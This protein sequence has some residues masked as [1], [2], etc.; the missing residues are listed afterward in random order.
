MPE[1]TIHSEGIDITSEDFNHVSTL[2][3]KTFDSGVVNLSESISTEWSPKSDFFS[4]SLAGKHVWL[5]AKSQADLRDKLLYFQ[6]EYDASPVLAVFFCLLDVTL[7]LR[8]TRV[9]EK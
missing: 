1:E 5:N 6:S 8:F 2:V 4:E 3:G 9:G 7:V